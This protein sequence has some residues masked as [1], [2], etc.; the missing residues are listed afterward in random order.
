MIHTMVLQ[1]CLAEQLL[2]K[3]LSEVQQ[4]TKNKKMKT[5]TKFLQEEILPQNA[6]PFNCV[7]QTL[8]VDIFCDRFVFSSHN[9]TK[10]QQAAHV[11]RRNAQLYNGVFFI[12]KTQGSCLVLV[13]SQKKQQIVI[14]T[15][16]IETSSKS[17]SAS[18]YF[19]YNML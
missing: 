8:G 1:L 19:S 13:A 17:Y 16:Q 9:L 11:T 2:H 6:L 12:K 3:A 4:L 7:D 5:L 10:R 18:L 15:L 14:W